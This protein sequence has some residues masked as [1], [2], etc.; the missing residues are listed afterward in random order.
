MANSCIPFPECVLGS[1]C[2]MLRYHSRGD[3]STWTRVVYIPMLNTLGEA[4]PL[5]NSGRWP[6]GRV[7][8]N[9]RRTLS[10]PE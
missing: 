7:C 4:N 5:A 1:S 9:P 6:A 2:D 10:R 8:G 3:A